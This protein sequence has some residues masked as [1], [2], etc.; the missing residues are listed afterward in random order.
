MKTLSS[1]YRS[2][3]LAQ[4]AETS[5]ERR[6]AFHLRYQ[7]YCLER[8][9]EPIE[10]CRDGVETD[11]HDDRA[12]HFITRYRHTGRALGVT[13]LVMDHSDAPLPIEAHGIAAVN[14]ELDRQRGM[15]R[16]LGEVSRLAVTRELKQ[17]CR[18]ASPQGGEPRPPRII[19]L[20]VSLGLLALLYKKSCQQ[21]ISHWVVLLDA[22]LVRCYARFG[23]QGE[24]LGPI[25]DHRGPRQPLLISVSEIG[26]RIQRRCP[27]LA[28]LVSDFLS[29]PIP[30][31]T[32]QPL[33]PRNTEGVTAQGRAPEPL[34]IAL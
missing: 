10:E 25:I 20:H 28:Q 34:P 33:Q 11:A 14:H 32:V 5:F 9:F 31:S 2:A 13:R 7:V 19:P 29:Q 18:P 1:L 24:P 4:T 30:G 12:I 15:G 22:A 21:R 16:R 27:P 23:I 6:E 8:G 3:L 17:L 26:E